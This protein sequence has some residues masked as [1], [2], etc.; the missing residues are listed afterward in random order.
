MSKFVLRQTRVGLL[1][2]SQF[3]NAKFAWKIIAQPFINAKCR[4]HRK[5]PGKMHYLKPFQSSVLGVIWC[6]L[7]LTLC[8]SN[9]FLNHEILLLLSLFLALCHFV[10]NSHTTHSSPCAVGYVLSRQCTAKSTAPKKNYGV[11]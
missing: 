11:R 3:H 1:Y 7:L 8:Q 10:R 4:I 2:G 9:A 5:C 6:T